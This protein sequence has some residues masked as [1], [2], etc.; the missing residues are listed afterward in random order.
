[1]NYIYHI[2]LVFSVS[3]GFFHSSSDWWYDKKDVL[4]ISVVSLQGFFRQ[5]L[6][7]FMAC[8]LIVQEKKLA[9]Y[10]VYTWS[11][12][13][14]PLVCTFLVCVTVSARQLSCKSGTVS[15]MTVRKTLILAQVHL[16]IF[17]ILLTSGGPGTHLWA[18]KC[19]NISL[20]AGLDRTWRFGMNL[21]MKGKCVTVSAT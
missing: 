6:T 2:N 12:T 4:W 15:C 17:L 16:H 10:W 8:P 5:Y 7:H 21:N 11:L 13:G 1:M 19:M 14:Q 18:W 20:S 9:K 3:N